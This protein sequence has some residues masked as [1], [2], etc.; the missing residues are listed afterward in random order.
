MFVWYGM[1]MSGVWYVCDICDIRYQRCV[2]YV[3]RVYDAMYVCMLGYDIWAVFTILYIHMVCVV[4]VYYC[5]C[6]RYTMWYV[7]S[8]CDVYVGCS[9][10]PLSFSPQGGRERL[11]LYPP[12]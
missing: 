11:S 4:Y 10:A 1:A 8:V 7:L 9:P 2:V 6:I 12:S 5:V 3:L